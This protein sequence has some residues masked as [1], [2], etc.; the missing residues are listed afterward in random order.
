MSPV[1]GGTWELEAQKILGIDHIFIH[2][3]HTCFHMTLLSIFIEFQNTWSIISVKYQSLKVLNIF[4]QAWFRRQST[5][6]S[7]TVAKNPACNWSPRNLSHSALSEK[8]YF[9]PPWRWGAGGEIITQ[10]LE[11]F[12]SCLIFHL[13]IALT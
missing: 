7:N 5:L 3:S 6:S 4:L 11:N 2:L 13:V 10:K 12:P 9:S 8:S 1:Y